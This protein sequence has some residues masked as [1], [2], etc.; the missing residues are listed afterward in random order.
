[1]D[2]H[3]NSPETELFSLA[4]FNVYNDKK[5]VERI[6]NTINTYTSEASAI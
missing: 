6:I 4:T 1:M 5:F 3:L 2:K